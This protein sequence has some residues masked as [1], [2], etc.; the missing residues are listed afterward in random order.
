MRQ[1]ACVVETGSLGAIGIGGFAEDVYRVL[2]TN[3][4]LTVEDLGLQL[5]SDEG[6]IRAVLVELNREGLVEESLDLP[7]RYVPV[8]PDL[9]LEARIMR[10]QAELDK[11]RALTK[12]LTARFHRGRAPHPPDLVEV[13]TGPEAVHR[14]FEDLQ[15]SAK[16]EV[17]CLDT[18]PYLGESGTPNVVEFEALARGVTYRAIYDRAALEAGP[19]TIKAIGRYAE[20]GEQARMVNHLPMKLVTIDREFGFLPLQTDQADVSRFLVI[21][22][23]S[24][25]DTLLFVFDTIWESATPITFDDA[26][27][28]LGAEGGD[29]FS[30]RERQILH[31][32]AA[33]MKDGAVAHHLGLSYST[34]RRRIGRL[35]ARL[36][37]ET[38]FQAGLQAALR[39]FGAPD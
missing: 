12:E 30:A 14:R 18:P 27:P 1:T 34:T 32:L 29:G 21:R 19:G 15:R 37:A 26:V 6:A 3:P 24:L 36:G 39:G 38:R 11:V 8:A 20:A 25:L 13:V 17:Q 16:V 7:T 9:G 2:V 10:A 4:G 35:M 28:V 5:G 33:G 31:L 22:P 23:C